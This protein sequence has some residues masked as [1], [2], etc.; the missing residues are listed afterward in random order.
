MS[1][2]KR[3]DHILTALIGF[4]ALLSVTILVGII[5]YVFWSRYKALS[6]ELWE[7]QETLST[8]FILSF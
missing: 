7:L 4:S 2:R 1:R 6:G 3:K 8:P 5:G